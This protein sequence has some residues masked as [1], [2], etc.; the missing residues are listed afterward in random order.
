MELSAL[1]YNTLLWPVES[2]IDNFKRVIVVP[3]DTPMPYH[4]LRKGRRK[5]KFLIQQL[6]VSYLPSASMILFQKPASPAAVDIV[7]I[8]HQGKTAWDVEYEVRDIRAFHKEAR[9]YFA[10]DASL[11]TLQ[12]EKAAILNLAA[13]FRFDAHRTGNSFL[14]LSDG[15]PAGSSEIPWGKL[16]AIPRYPAV[17]LSDLGEHHG[18]PPVKPLLFLVNGSETVV[19]T[20]SPARR[21]TKKYFGEFFYTAIAEGSLS[22][23]AYRRAILEMIVNPDVNAVEIWS[24]FYRWGI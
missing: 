10:K 11:A 1:L 12:R 9:L 16:V 2:S 24:P 7:G 22:D 23:D 17:V 14:R 18:I 6:H 5:A 13:E 19:L 15:T 3:Y 4:A 20:S 21:K 8:G